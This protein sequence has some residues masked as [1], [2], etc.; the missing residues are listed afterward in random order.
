MLT[1][2][3]Q[4]TLEGI[5][6]EKLNYGYPDF[7]H[8]LSEHAKIS[9]FQK[10]SVNNVRQK[11]GIL[12]GPL[13]QMTKKLSFLLASQPTCQIILIDISKHLSAL[14][15]IM[16]KTLLSL[17]DD[18]I[19][20]LDDTSPIDLGKLPQETT[21]LFVS[22]EFASTMNNTPDHIKT[23]FTLE[24]D[25]CKVDLQTR[26]GSDVDLICQL[27][28]ELYRCCENEASNYLK[29][30]NSSMAERKEQQAK[31]IH[32]ELK[33]AYSEH[34]VHDS[35][36]KKSI[37][38]STTTSIT[39]TTVLWLK[40]KSQNDTD[41]KDMKE[42]LRHVV[43]SLEAFENESACQHYLQR[44][45]YDHG[46]FLIIS[47]DYA[48]S[49]IIDLQRFQ[50]VQTIYCYGQSSLTNIKTINNYN[51]LCFQ[52]VYDLI[53]FYKNLADTYNAEQNTIAADNVRMKAQKLCK[54]LASL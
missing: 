14:A 27:A 48:D 45:E 5:A 42:L 34:S 52:L 6:Q 41:V 17:T 38:T 10:M 37:P 20:V 26:F 51:H 1:F 35:T 22:S 3:T 18:S 33:K 21:T 54:I 7:Y 16:L 25:Q 46:L 11:V 30:G 40:S 2:L 36:V 29:A 9:R 28:D 15:A 32:I 8:D 43:A 47:A 31:R 19:L 4:V 13:K 24:T 53:D 23:V 39:A 44:N 12:L 49:L 50:N